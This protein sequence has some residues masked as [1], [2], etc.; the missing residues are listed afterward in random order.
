[1]ARFILLA[2]CVIAPISPELCTNAVLG[3]LKGF[4]CYLSCI[5]S[6]GVAMEALGVTRGNLA[7]GYPTLAGSRRSMGRGIQVAG[8]QIDKAGQLQIGESGF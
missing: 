4:H 8:G 6:V 3:N 5:C 7:R 1:M 2:I